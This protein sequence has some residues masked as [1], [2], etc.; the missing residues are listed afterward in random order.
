MA[1][2]DI[3]FN[4]DANQL[5]NISTVFDKFE[6]K[7]QAKIVRDSFFQAAQIVKNDAIRRTPVYTGDLANSI[8][9]RRFK[10]GF[11]AGVEIFAGVFYAKFI[12]FGYRVVTRG[13]RGQGEKQVAGHVPARPFMRPALEE[14]ADAV[15]EKIASDLSKLT[16][17][18]TP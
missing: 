11:E 10:R 14:N 16:L 18:T 17:G 1:T 8:K 13:W 12:E 15:V 5:R 4:I 3:S 6:Q 7:V 9:V 2:E